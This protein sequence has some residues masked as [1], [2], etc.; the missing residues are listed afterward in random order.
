MSKAISGLLIFSTGCL[1][2]AS[3]AF[4]ALKT[5]F[6]NKL[7]EELDKAKEE[8]KKTVEYDINVYDPSPK[9][10][11]I[12]AATKETEDENSFQNTVASVIKK[13]MVRENEDMDICGVDLDDN[14]LPIYLIS[15][16][17]FGENGYDQKQLFYYA[18]DETLC[19]EDDEVID[20]DESNV[21][22]NALDV[23]IYTDVD[24]CYV[25]NNETKTDYDIVRVDGSFAS[26]ESEGLYE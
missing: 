17:E 18:A 23:F 13:A 8:D 1:T 14:S 4:A 11:L 15:P 16:N 24:H 9:E 12:N 21:G 10:E 5:S 25:R 3:I 19:D 6:E 26:Y 2:G 7:K 20:P 22:E